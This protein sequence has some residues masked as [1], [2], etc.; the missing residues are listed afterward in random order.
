MLKN[1]IKKPIKISA[2]KLENTH[3]SIIEASWWDKNH[4][5][6]YGIILISIIP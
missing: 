4:R 1:Y 6:Y 5:R 3:E 2:M